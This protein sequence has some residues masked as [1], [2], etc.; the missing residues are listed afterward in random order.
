MRTRTRRMAAVALSGL[1]A[2]VVGAAPAAADVQPNVTWRS[3]GYSEA[4]EDDVGGRD[5]YAS[6]NTGTGSAYEA[7]FRAYGEWFWVRENR[8]DGH[9]LRAYL[10]VE[11]FGTATYVINTSGDD[12][13]LSFPEGRAVS[14]K[15]CIDGTSTC[16]NWYG[17]GRT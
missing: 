6:L 10:S 17:G 14:V 13:N 5:V 11:G 7:G 15:V 3:Y 8:T 1:T 2:T 9:G 4:S 16:S 12:W